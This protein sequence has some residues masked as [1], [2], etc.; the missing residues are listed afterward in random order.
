M[1]NKNIVEIFGD[2]PKKRGGKT[3]IW[4]CYENLGIEFNFLNCSWNDTENP[5]I[6]VCVFK[7]SKN[8]SKYNCNLC[9]K[10]VN[11]LEFA[12]KNNCNLVN[13]CSRKCYDIHFPIHFSSC[14]NIIQN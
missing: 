9:L 7:P 1:V 2:T 3:P 5:I 13:Y 14:K 10:E 12:C 6:F 8:I 11:K 4:L